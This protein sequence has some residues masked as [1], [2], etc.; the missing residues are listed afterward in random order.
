MTAAV[1]LRARLERLSRAEADADGVEVECVHV[2]RAIEK[3][4]GPGGAILTE[5]G[6]D[7]LVEGTLHATGAPRPGDE[8]L[9]AAVGISLPA[10]RRAAD[11]SFGP[12]SLEQPGG[13]LLQAVW[14]GALACARDL[15]ATELDSGHLAVAVLEAGQV[16]VRL[17][18]L[19][20]TDPQVL[21]SRARE[22]V[23]QG[24]EVARAGAEGVKRQMRVSVNKPDLFWPFVIV[25]IGVV[26]LLDNL[27]V[28]AKGALDRFVSLWPLL[29]ILLGVGLVVERLGLR[30]RTAHVVGQAIGPIFV[31]AAVLYAIFGLPHPG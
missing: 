11:A 29:L 16:A 1:A 13:G 7:R 14:D 9:L 10:I 5:L 21:V 6:V 24:L 3:M 8:A 26:V 31:V 4:D 18:L 25:G 28:V 23:A 30:S 17:G 12:G 2:L 19:T 20:G 22:R 15:G 27:G